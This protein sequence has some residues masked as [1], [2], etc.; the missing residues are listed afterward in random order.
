MLAGARIVEM[1][2]TPM[3]EAVRGLVA[4]VSVSIWLFGS[5]LIPVLVAAGW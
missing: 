4:G 3:V 2:D 5:W 1:V